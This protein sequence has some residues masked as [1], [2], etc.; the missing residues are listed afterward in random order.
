MHNFARERVNLATEKMKIR[1][2]TRATGHHFNEGDKVW[3]WN[4]TR[5]KGFCPKLQSRW[6][7]SYTVLNRLNDVVVWIRKSSNS[8][9]VHYSKL[10]PYYGQSVLTYRLFREFGKA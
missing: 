10:A 3:L 4:S 5:R 8:K 2:E 7:D 9:V 6:D 1:Y